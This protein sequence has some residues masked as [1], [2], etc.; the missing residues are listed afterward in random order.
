[1]AALARFKKGVMSGKER[2]TGWGRSD[3]K[4]EGVKERRV[5]GKGRRK[6]GRCWKR[7]VEAHHGRD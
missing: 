3:I 7:E 5:E 4:M 6:T 2:N 1:M